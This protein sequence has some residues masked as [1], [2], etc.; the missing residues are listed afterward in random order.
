MTAHAMKGDRERCLV[1]GMD[2]YISKPV[3]TKELLAA[4]ARQLTPQ[5][6]Q[7]PAAESVADK[8]AFAQIFDSATALERVEGDRKLLAEM[9]KLL[10]S[11][12]P[13]LLEQLRTAVAQADTN[14]LERAAHTLKG[15]LGSL[16]ATAAFSV[17]RE[18]ETAARQNDFSRARSLAAVLE[19][20]IERLRP[21][22]EQF[23]VEVSP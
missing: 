1:V 17:A 18:L 6:N 4:M 22:L 2:D 10:E 20:E 13:K 7:A 19:K 9:A 5:E 3:Q 12:S 16:A 8:P 21:A 23:C 15:A 11:E 14:G